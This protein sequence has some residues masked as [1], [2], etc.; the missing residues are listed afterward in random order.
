MA[1]PLHSFLDAVRDVAA[2]LAPSALGAAVAQAYQKGLS[3][4]DRLIQWAVG[5]AVSHFVTRAIAAWL[6]LQLE[7][8]QGV[9]FVLGVIAFQATPKFIAGAGD[10]LGGLPTSIRDFF[11]K[12]GQ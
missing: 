6:G 10:T 3:F 8:G 11:L 2:A 12:R 4:R 5:I 1:D 7:V 9:G